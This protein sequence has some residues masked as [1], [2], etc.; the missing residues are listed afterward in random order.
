MESLERKLT[1]HRRQLLQPFEALGE[2]PCPG[3]ELLATARDRADETLKQLTEIEGRRSKLVEAES[4]LQRQVDAAQA[5]GRAVQ[6]RLDAWRSEWAAVVAPLG[7]DAEAPAEQVLDLV[8]Q[9]AD[10]QAR[11]KEARD[12]QSRMSGLQR[13]A[14]QFA[15]DLEDVCRR[16][17]PDLIADTQA[18]SPSVE[19]AAAE[20]LRRFRAAQEARPPRGP[21]RATRCRTGQSREGG[22][23]ARGSRSTPCIAVP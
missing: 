3:D 9:A 21:D 22:S 18:G 14:A 12:T 4:K 10:L 16:V 11:I 17:A 15:R 19:A 23:V 6:G 1:T 20:L 7:L 13:E 5:E 8:N 2:P